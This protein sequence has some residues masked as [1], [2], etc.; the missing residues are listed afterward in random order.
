MRRFAY[1][2]VVLATS[3]VWVMVDM[4][5]LL[6]FS[7]CNKCDEKRERG[8]PGR[9]GECVLLHT[10]THRCDR[11]DTSLPNCVYPLQTLWQGH[12][13]DLVRGGSLWWSLRRT[14]RRWR[15][16]S[17]STSSTSWPLRWLLSIVRCLMS[18]L[19]GERPSRHLL[20]LNLICSS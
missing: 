5:I 13:M 9:D 2:K 20:F 4:F 8:L 17:R 19:K 7:E 6:Y 10:P 16:C 15:T 3:L 11:G 1:C 18:A 12:G 14:R